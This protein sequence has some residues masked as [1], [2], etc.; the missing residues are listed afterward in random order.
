MITVYK[1]DLWGTW[2]GQR[3]AASSSA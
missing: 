1:N 3:N 2:S